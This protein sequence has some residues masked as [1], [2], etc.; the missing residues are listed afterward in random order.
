MVSEEIRGMIPD[1]VRGLLPPEE[2]QVVANALSTI[3]MLAKELDAAKRYYTVLNQL[4]E[5]DVPVDFLDR[6]NRR[7][8][9]K[10]WIQNIIDLFFKPFFPKIPLEF[11]GLAACLVVVV[12]MLKPELALHQKTELPL[13]INTSTY[14]NDESPKPAVSQD[15]K[16]VQTPAHLLPA[17]KKVDRVPPPVA[18]EL[19][20]IKKAPVPASVLEKKAADD[21]HALNA[22]SGVARTP[23]EKYQTDAAQLKEKEGLL[24]LKESE[25]KPVSFAA[26]DIGAIEIS[27]VSTLHKGNKLRAAKSAKAPL[28]RL[29]SSSEHATLANSAVSPEKGKEAVPQE[30]AYSD[31]PDQNASPIS[32]SEILDSI[33]VKYD[34][35]LTIKSV[36]GMVSYSLTLSPDRLSALSKDLQQS[37]SV[38][39]HLLPFDPLTAKMVKVSFTVKE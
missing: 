30:D 14:L 13:V 32:I 4:P 25:E 8:D 39:S 17:A 33:L 20:E 9:H 12:V 5:S 28:S 31:L 7:I 34:S 19:P 23:S 10:P 11:A 2:A 29:E 22:A 26:V 16:Q 35:L 36:H 1:Y 15:K 21:N 24:A 27:Y 18:M 38:T 37:F 3:P 6:I